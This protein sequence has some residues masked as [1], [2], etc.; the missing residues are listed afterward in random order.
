MRYNSDHDVMGSC[1]VLNRKL[2]RSNII[3]DTSS[4]AAA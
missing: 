4:M 1:N 2:H 3:T